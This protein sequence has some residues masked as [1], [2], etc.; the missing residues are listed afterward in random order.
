MT[1][2]TLDPHAPPAPRRLVDGAL[3]S[4]VALLVAV[5][6]LVTYTAS[7]RTGDAVWGQGTFFL[8]R[9]L[10]WALL[11]AGVA[12]VTAGVDYRVWRRYSVPI[13]AC[14]LLMLLVMLVAGATRFGGQ[15]WLTA[16]GSVQPSELAKLAVIIYLADWLASKRRQIRD[17]TLG[18]I[19]YAILIGLVC[20]LIVL[21]NHLSTAVLV[22]VV[23]V[24]MYFTAGAD[25]KQMLV[26]GVIAATVLG[27][28]IVPVPYRMARVRTFMDPSAD[29][30]DAGYQILRSLEAIAQGGVF[31]VGLGNGQHKHLIP[32]AHTD[33][34]FAVLGEELGL[35]GGLTMLALFGLLAWRGFRIAARS[36]DDF[37]SLLALGITCWLTV[38]ALINIAVV[39][40][41][42]PFTGIPLPFV[43]YGGSSLV[44]CMAAAGLLLNLSRQVDPD[45]DESHAYLDFGWWHQRSRLSRAHR[46][47]S[48]GR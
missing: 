5:G 15:R 36:R 29:P 11:G 24:I 39:T 17:V 47:R 2:A 30:S 43:S 16:G 37:A 42:M 22:G 41:M 31:G 34:A 32:A 12:G 33:A 19:P 23:A 35:A 9:Q 48:R 4:V 8:K 28:L 20:G 14:T 44:V 10:V 38:Q 26:S 6:F 46:A 7:Y 13:M 45:R 1:A 25:L 3:L 18:L 27:L 40:S 21:Q